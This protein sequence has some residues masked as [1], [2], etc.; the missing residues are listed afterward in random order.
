LFP[1]TVGNLL[2]DREALS[3]VLNL[4]NVNERYAVGD[5]LSNFITVVA[6][7]VNQQKLAQVRAIIFVTL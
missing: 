5:T 6:P 7:M 2:D 3:N 1:K 4:V